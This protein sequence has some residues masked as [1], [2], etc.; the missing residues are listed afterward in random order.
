[1]NAHRIG[2]FSDIQAMVYDIEDELKHDCDDAGTARAPRYQFEHSILEN[3][4]RAHRRQRTFAWSRS[5]CGT[6]NQTIGVWHAWLRSKIVEL[7]VE[8]HARPL[9]HH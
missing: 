8:E 9:G 6:A 4:G 2:G 1:M 3:H 7:I 5:V